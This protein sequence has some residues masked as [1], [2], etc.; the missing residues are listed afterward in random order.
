MFDF[1]FTKGHIVMKSFMK[2]IQAAFCGAAL[3][4]ISF[5]SMAGANS[6]LEKKLEKAAKECAEFENGVLRSKRAGV[7]EIEAFSNETSAY[8]INY[9]EIDCSSGNLYWCGN[10]G[11]A[12]DVIIGEESHEFFA[13][14]Y[15]VHQFYDLP[16]LLFAH[17]GSFC[18]GAGVDAC[19]SIAFWSGEKLLTSTIT[20]SD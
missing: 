5:V 2:L 7:K 13:R 14:D 4:S 6:L 20:K 18:D 15:K 10:G 11:C 9:G 3:A 19:F 17:H 12:I 1:Y 16:I 8:V